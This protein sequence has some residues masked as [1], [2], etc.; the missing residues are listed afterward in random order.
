VEDIANLAG[1]LFLDV[2]HNCIE[3][4]D[5]RQLPTCI[6]FL[7]VSPAQMHM[8]R[9]RHINVKH[10]CIQVVFHAA[11]ISNQCHGC[12]AHPATSYTGYKDCTESVVLL[13]FLALNK[14]SLQSENFQEIRQFLIADKAMAVF[15]FRLCATLLLYRAMDFSKSSEKTES[16]IAGQRQNN[17][18]FCLLRIYISRTFR[19]IPRYSDISRASKIT[20]TDHVMLQWLAWHIDETVFAWNAWAMMNNQL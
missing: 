7:K 15:G 12:C 13:A 18:H 3:Q 17:G 5:V 10:C 16:L 20:G 1:L 4:L 8:L 9:N 14:T 2:S 6:R 19:Q 11:L